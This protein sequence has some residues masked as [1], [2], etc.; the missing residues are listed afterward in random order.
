M[1]ALCIDNV[2]TFVAPM[3]SITLGRWYDV[4]EDSGSLSY[5]FW[6]SDDNGFHKVSLRSNFK[7]LEQVRD[8]RL[9]ELFGG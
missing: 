7:T 5:Y 4:M 8:E 9:V 3:V 1:R 2:S 6:I